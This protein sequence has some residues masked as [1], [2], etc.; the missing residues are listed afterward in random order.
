D[1]AVAIESHG[2][3]TTAEKAR[4]GTGTARISLA[5]M[6]TPCSTSRCAFLLGPLSVRSL[7][8]SFRATP[9][10]RGRVRCRRKYGFLPP[11]CASALCQPGHPIVGLSSSE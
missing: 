2:D 11:A 10:I 1:P 8:Q 6:A 7:G 9:E 3:A 4:R 5:R